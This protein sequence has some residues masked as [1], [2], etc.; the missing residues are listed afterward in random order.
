V[1]NSDWENA[2]NYYVLH[3]EMEDSL[4]NVNVQKNTLRKKLEYDHNLEKTTEA[5][6]TE[7]EK[8]RSEQAMLFLMVGLGVVVVFAL[9]VY[10]RLRITRRQKKIIEE[11]KELVDEKNTEIVDSI[12]YAK[13]LQDAILPNQ[14]S[15]SDNFNDSFIFYLPK[16]IVAGDFYWFHRE[17]DTVFVAAA[18]CTGHG[19]PGAMV[20]VVCANAL[21][22]AVKE[23]RLTNTG[24]ILDKVRSLVVQTFAKSGENV[25][26][27]MDISL[28][29]IDLSSNSIEF[30]GANNPLWIIKNGA[31]DVTIIKGDRQ[32]VGQF[33]KEISFHSHELTANKGDWIYLFSDGYVDQFGGD[34]GKK[35]KS[36]NLKSLLSDISHHNGEEQKKEIEKVFNDWKGELEQ[37]DDVCMIGIQI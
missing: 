27:G 1:R 7:E 32:P 21:D 2:L 34:K 24:L 37:L 6:K 3:T 36:S 14:K 9:I 29:K 33:E 16:D 13:R 18:D 15:I 25:K 8:K 20:S 28:C 11:Q 10:S 23:F 30:S 26:D 4:Y 35:F 12:N 19:V 5:L 22:Q 31:E 17:N